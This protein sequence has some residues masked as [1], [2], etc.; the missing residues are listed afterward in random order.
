MTKLK[1][2]GVEW[3]GKIPESWEIRKLKYILCERK[4]KN[5]P[6]KTDFILSLS[7]EKGVFPYSE[8]DG[9]GNKAKEDFSKYK[10]ARPNDIVINSMNFIYGAVGISKWL[11]ALSPVYLTYY[12][13]DN[14]ININYYHYLFQSSE[15]QK[16]LVGLGNGILMIRMR[17][18]SDKLNDLLLPIPSIDEQE[19]IV[20]FL[21]NQTRL[22]DEIITDTKQSIEEL[23]LYKQSIIT[24]VVTKGI[25]PNVEYVSSGID[26]IGKIPDDWSVN[27]LGFLGSLQ[28]G[29]S[30]S[31]DEFG[32]GLPFVT[33]GDV[34]NNFQLPSTPSGLVNSTKQDRFLYSVKRGD[35]FF[36]RT[37]ETADEIGIA[38]TNLQ[39]IIN[40][41]F[42]GFLIRFRP[43]NKQLDTLFSKY[44]FRS[45]IGKIFMSREMNIV[46][47]ASLS[48]NL[49]KKFPV[50]LP[51]LQEQQAIA[52]FLD[53]KTEFINKI[54]IDKKNLINEFVSYKKSLIY[55]YVT[56]KK[57][58]VI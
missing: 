13:N 26:W 1:D 39:D 9:G 40:A 12:S 21:D 43:T 3:I 17:I 47:R 4:E 29:I 55:E 32:F 34:Y 57:Q 22:I 28:N 14:L 38:S 46:T 37:S 50:L 18:P 30:K 42:S 45:D 52:D 5:N 48:Q 24:G 7:I 31:G 15:F 53:N 56:G 49:L 54:V 33:Y 6:I 23:K 2:S 19:K 36:T 10:V 11:G 51:P 41:T 27:K 8:K 16:S 58:V 25:N 35:I 20:K 44:Y